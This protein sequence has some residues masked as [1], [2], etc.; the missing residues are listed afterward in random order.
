MYLK[1]VRGRTGRVFGAKQSNSGEVNLIAP[2]AGDRAAYEFQDSVDG[3]ITWLGLTP[4]VTTKA[5]ATASGLKP[6]ST[7]HFRYRATVKERH[8][9]LERPRGD[10]RV[11]GPKLFSERNR[12][13]RFVE[14]GFNGRPPR[15][16]T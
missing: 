10:H 6:G 15:H 5:S 14:M 3:G 11:V 16:V 4:P 9:G 13:M 2:S 8:R 1:K 12:Q 7:V